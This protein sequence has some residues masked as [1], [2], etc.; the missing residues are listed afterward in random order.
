MKKLLLGTVAALAL[1]TTGVY[2]RPDASLLPMPSDETAFIDVVKHARK[3]YDT[4]SNEMA[5][6]AARPARKKELCELRL[7][8]QV[9]NWIGVLYKQSSKWGR[10]GRYCYR[11]RQ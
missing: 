5:K 7:S 3:L 10:Q 4:G 6:G 8:T 9:S 2:A 1:T 11:P